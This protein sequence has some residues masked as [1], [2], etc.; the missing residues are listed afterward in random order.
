MLL[1]A[2]PARADQL[3]D[4]LNLAETLIGF[5][6]YEQALDLLPP[7][8]GGLSPIQTGR[9]W[10]LRGLAHTRV[11][12]S[13]TALEDLDRAVAA[14]PEYKDALLLRAQLRDVLDQPDA[15]QTWYALRQKYPADVEI[16]Y[17]A[18]KY[19]LTHD[20]QEGGTQAL[21]I[22]AV[23]RHPWALPAQKL[24]GRI[25][26]TRP[27]DHPSATRWN[28]RIEIAPLVN[29]RVVLSSETIDLPQNQVGDVGLRAAASV[30]GQLEG[31]GDGLWLGFDYDELRY[32]DFQAY[33]TRSLRASLNKAWSPEDG[34]PTFW[35]GADFEAYS[36]GG[37]ALFQG[38]VFNGAL[39][40]RRDLGAV[41][42]Q[43]NVG[44]RFFSPTYSEFT[45]SQIH[46]SGEFELNSP[47]LGR[48]S[49]APYLH[50]ELATTSV[51]SY[52]EGGIT[53]GGEALGWALGDWGAIHPALLGRVGWRRYDAVDNSTLLKQPLRRQDMAYAASVKFLYDVPPG[54]SPLLNQGYFG[55]EWQG[56]RSNI[57]A[58]AVWLPANNRTWSTTIYSVGWVVQ[59]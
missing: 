28:G 16:A 33:E 53:L 17:W 52:S 15:A 1:A 29:K 57:D 25:E 8:R 42:L 19:L 47:L 44:R 55:V 58:S 7:P 11:G 12:Q 23:G 20:D 31:I 18:G 5:K 4:D 3:D 13:K 34:G 59:F 43:L 21:Q 6:L 24:L 51:R 2:L 49:A 40:E 41:R 30:Q 36:I 39:E 14:L 56:N 22:A 32:Q 54:D 46:L 37:D 45:A 10:Y 35:G 48:W 26:A 50:K 27:P 38:V 9:L